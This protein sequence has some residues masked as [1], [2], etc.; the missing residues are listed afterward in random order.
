MIAL[1]II[2]A[3]LFFVV[4]NNIAFTLFFHK[5]IVMNEKRE[6]LSVANS[7]INYIA[8]IEERYL[9]IS[10]V[11]G[12]WDD[13]FNFVANQN[14]DFIVSNLNESTFLNLG[15][16]FIM[17]TKNDDKIIYKGYYDGSLL[18]HVANDILDSINKV[19]PVIKNSENIFGMYQLGSSY[20]F[21]SSSMITD[22]LMEKPSIGHIII[23]KELDKQVIDM[24]NVTTSTVLNKIS[25]KNIN[26]I[27]PKNHNSSNYFVEDN[28]V[29]SKDS[30]T[31][32]LIYFNEDL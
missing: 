3:I 24:L 10:N 19:L 7:V 20:Y 14:P 11:W 22:S 30:I 28:A 16:N 5:E 12:H 17:L 4:A 26:E 27:M 29:F 25:H 1:T 2:P 9:G 31:F 18:A 8:Q 23:G 13:T 32:N 21:L 6:V 15:V